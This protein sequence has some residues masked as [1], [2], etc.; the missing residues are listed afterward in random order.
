MPLSF[1]RRTFVLGACAAAT[2][3][4]PGSVRVGCQANGFPLKPGDFAAFLQALESMKNLGYTGFECNYRFV[5]AQ[6]GRAAEARE[7]I[8]RT[9]VTFIGAHIGMDVLG[10][11]QGARIA[12]GVA[13]LGADCMVM[14]GKGLSPEGRFEKAAL[15]QKAREMETIARMLQDHRLRLTYHNHNPEFANANA[16]MNGLAENTSP[17]LVGFLMDAG[18]GYLGGGDPAAFLS[19]HSGRVYGIHLKTF[20]GKE[21]SGQVPLGQGDFDFQALAAA[22]K[23]ASW[24]GWLITEEGGGS[25]PGNTAALASD[26]AHIRKLFGV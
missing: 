15:L 4:A 16:E 11:A 13:S 20:R 14:S 7:Q 8:E 26:R 24:R 12:R 5:E 17:A 1:S 10:G 6:F 22:V 3:A 19:A 25:K 9:G 2:G 23:K 21:V 18:H